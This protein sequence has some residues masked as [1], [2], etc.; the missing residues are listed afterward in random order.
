MRLLVFTFLILM[1]VVAYIAYL[2]PF[3]VTVFY[4]RDESVETSVTALILFSMASGGLLVLIAAG[5]I[6]TRN[7]FVSWRQNQLRKRGEKIGEHLETGTNALASARLEEAVAAFQKALQLD[8][9]NVP[10]L[11]KLGRVFREQGSLIEAVRIHR[12]ALDRD[13]RNIEVAL[14]LARDFE[15]AKQFE[16]ATSVLEEAVKVDGGSRTALFR[17][18]DLYSKLDLWEEAHSVQEKILNLSLDRTELD[19]EQNW[20][21]GIK[22]ELGRS[23]LEKDVMD[24]ARRHFRGAIKLK[25]DF[26]PAYIGL[27][28]VLV[29]EG[30]QKEAGELWEKAFEMTGNVI[31]LHRLEELYLEM[32]QP[33]RIIKLYEDAVRRDPSNPVLQFY[34]GKLFYRLEML[35]EAYSVLTGID[36]A[37]EK[38]PDLYKILGNL[39][40]RRGE[41]AQ[42][43]EAFKRALNLK[44]RVLV[45]Y[46]CPLCDYHTTQWA[47]RC[48]RCNAWNSYS[49]SPV[50]GEWTPVRSLARLN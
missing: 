28:E 50:L 15:E 47:G 33:P 37:D 8:S 30:K 42:A 14:A 44:K 24:R 10:A 17:L 3:N 43:V 23:S 39:Y 22:Y 36:G 7:L 34:L 48:A 9:A 4:T 1:T 6:E 38:M 32:G 35:D 40:L 45:P 20:M 29:Q 16:E 13:P 21:A 49:A 11:L 12:R 26:L 27:G 5:F 18:R 41:N 2:N 46:Y 19:R 31:L 25:K